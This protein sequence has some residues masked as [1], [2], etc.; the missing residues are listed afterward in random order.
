MGEA[1]RKEMRATE[2]TGKAREIDGIDA[3]TALQKPAKIRRGRSSSET[4]TTDH[5]MGNDG[6]FKC[7]D[8]C[9]VCQGF[10]YFGVQSEH[11]RVQRAALQRCT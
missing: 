10:V 3:N 2:G 4:P 7:H 8:R 11:T 5:A 6:A 1:E 9:V